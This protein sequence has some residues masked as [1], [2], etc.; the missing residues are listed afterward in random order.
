MNDA[1]DP[2]EEPDVEW[3]WGCHGTPL[4]IVGAD[5]S[6]HLGTIRTDGFASSGVRIERVG[7]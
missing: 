1:A 3:V 5:K 4:I 6:L 7:A 2:V